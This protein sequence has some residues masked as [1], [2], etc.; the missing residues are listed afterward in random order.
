MV[1]LALKGPLQTHPVPPSRIDSLKL[2]MSP[3]QRV[4]SNTLSPL[5]Q[6]CPCNQTLLNYF[7][8]KVNQ[9]LMLGPL[10]RKSI[11]CKYHEICTFLHAKKADL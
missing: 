9:D 6:T 10:D 4:D 2:T 1:S 7:L 3:S 11:V 8:K 5:D